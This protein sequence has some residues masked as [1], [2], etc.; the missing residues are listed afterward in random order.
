MNINSTWLQLKLLG[1]N[2]QLLSSVILARLAANNQLF[3]NRVRIHSAIKF[4]ALSVWTCQPI[5][6][7]Y[8]CSSSCSWSIYLICWLTKTCVTHC[9]FK[10]LR[11]HVLASVLGNAAGH[12]HPGLRFLVFMCFVWNEMT[13]GS[14]QK[15]DSV[16]W[17]PSR[18][19]YSPRRSVSGKVSG[20]VIASISHTDWL[21]FFFFLSFRKRWR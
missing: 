4:S 14:A 3:H 12:R 5:S 9:V 15:P 11:K 6:P 19:N 13:S 10:S 8:R 16:T 20:C 7:S 2:G 21:L 17:P 18:I 1:C